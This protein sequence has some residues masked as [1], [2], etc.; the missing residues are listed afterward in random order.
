MKRFNTEAIV[1]TRINY[2][3][4]DRIMN[5][6]T[7]H[8]GK[9][10]AIAKGVRKSQSK[11]AG[12]IELFSV[13]QLTVIVGRSDI[14]TVISS[15]LIRHWGH[16]VQDLERT[17][18]GY[19]VIRLI[20][21]AT[22]AAP[23]PA[24]FA[25]LRRALEAL[26]DTGLDPQLIALWFNMQLLKLTGHQPNL[27]TDTSGIKLTPSQSYDFRLDQM[28]F[29]P[30]V[31]RSGAFGANHIKF[32]RLGFAAAHPHLLQRVKDAPSLADSTR[33]LVQTMLASFVRI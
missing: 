6:L 5:F 17:K 31:S 4:A 18:T 32:L 8:H 21:K 16:I 26:D 11:L 2:G 30:Q 28:R 3:E 19:E 14:N 29:V 23:E 25:L 15:R 13:S 12:G 33:P 22:E 27:R 20:H 7:P 1:L 10:S 9:I 24:Y